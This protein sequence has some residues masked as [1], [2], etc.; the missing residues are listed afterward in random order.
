MLPMEIPHATITIQSPQRPSFYRGDKVTLRCDIT[1]EG[2]VYHWERNNTSIYNHINT[3][4]TILLPEES[5]HYTCFGMRR[6]LRSY[7]S[8]NMTIS[9]S[10]SG[11]SSFIMAFIMAVAGGVVLTIMVVKVVPRCCRKQRGPVSNSSSSGL[12][13]SPSTG[14]AERHADEHQ[15]QSDGGGLPV[16]ETIPLTDQSRPVLDTVYDKLSLSKMGNLSSPYNP[17]QLVE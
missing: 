14:L 9:T 4:I 8:P 17:Y 5:G 1:S 6:Q 13:L 12:S 15:H 16:Y 2:W 11:S 3:T 10:G 7:N